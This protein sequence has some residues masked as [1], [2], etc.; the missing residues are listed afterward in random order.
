MISDTRSYRDEKIDLVKTVAIWSVVLCHVATAPFSGST[1]G[2][3]PWYSALFWAGLTHMCVPL[4]F[5]A[6]GALLLKP[7]KELTLKKLYTKNLARILAALFFWALCYKLVSLQLMN[8]LTLPDVADAV[9]HL[10]LFHHEEHFYYLHITLLAYAVLPVTR[11]VAKYAD[12]RL[13]EYALVL[14]FLLGILY[15][16]VRTFWP[17][18]LLSGVPVQWRMNMT[19]ASIGY[20]LLG[21]Y[22]SVYHPRPDRGLSALTLLTGFLLAFWGTCFASYAAGRSSEHFLEGM[23]LSMFLAAL[24]AWG[25]CQTVPLSQTGRKLVTFISKASFCIYLL[26]IFFLQAFAHLDLRAV[27][28]PVLLTVP[29][30]SGLTICCCCAAYAALSRI[31]VV[32]RWLI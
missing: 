6:S 12:K 20:M 32:R 2:T 13:L 28:G 29:L 4:F 30:I 1:V 16:T 26:H 27:D 5:M 3:T 21:Y 19:Y 14:W 31:P 25:L 8:S 9:K 22:L 18:T 15:P 10:L 17:F 24:G 23:G 11:L 7:E